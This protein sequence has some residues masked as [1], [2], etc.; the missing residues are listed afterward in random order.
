MPG[1]MEAPIWRPIVNLTPERPGVHSG[2]TLSRMIRRRFDA[3][4]Q[5]KIPEHFSK[6]IKKLKTAGGLGSTPGTSVEQQQTA[7]LQKQS[8][9]PC[10]L[11]LGT[12]ANAAQ[13]SLL[14]ARCGGRGFVNARDQ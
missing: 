14:C 3:V 6:L 10:P 4:T 13:P 8:F 7:E 1:K 11:C 12:G 2:G 9:V 5:E